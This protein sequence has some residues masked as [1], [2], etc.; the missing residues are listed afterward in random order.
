MWTKDQF[1]TFF[2]IGILYD[3]AGAPQD[4]IA[5]ALVKFAL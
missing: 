1:F 4:N 5:A 3:I 2:E